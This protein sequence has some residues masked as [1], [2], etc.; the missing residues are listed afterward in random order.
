MATPSDKYGDTDL[1]KHV[2]KEEEDE[3]DWGD[4]PSGGKGGEEEE[5]ERGIGSFPGP[6]T[7]FRRA[8]VRR[9]VETGISSPW[10]NF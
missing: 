1:A 6:P 2:R 5:E 9:N 8:H 3:E 10:K 4:G 7:V